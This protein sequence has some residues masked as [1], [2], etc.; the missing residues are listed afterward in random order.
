LAMGFLKDYFSLASEII[1]KHRGILDKFIGDDVM[2]IFGV[3]SSS[4]NVDKVANAAVETALDLRDEFGKLVDRWAKKWSKF[5]PQKID[6]GLRCG[7]NTG[8]ATV[9]SIG[10]KERDQFTVIGSTP[11]IAGRL[12]AYAKD[13]E[14]LVSTPT[15]NRI[16][17]GFEL[18]RA[19]PIRDIKNIEGEFECYIVKGKLSDKNAVDIMPTMERLSRNLKGLEWKFIDAENI[20]RA[21]KAV[22]LKSQSGELYPSQSFLQ[23]PR[24]RF[25]THCY[26]WRL[27]LK[28]TTITAIPALTESNA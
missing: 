1:S 27:I 3:F 17:A 20:Y 8:E 16:L 28:K 26:A 12:E 24:G 4:K 14:I 11:N 2:A 23:S 18:I 21:F 22:I 15:G 9:G 19:E 7:I 6:I 10:A 13:M 25:R 5:V